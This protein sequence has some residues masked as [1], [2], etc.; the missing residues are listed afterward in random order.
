MVILLVVEVV[1]REPLVKTETIL[2]MAEMAGLEP[3]T[4]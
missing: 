3:Q 4:Q 1:E 2:T